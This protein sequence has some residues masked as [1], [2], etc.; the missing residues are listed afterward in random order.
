MYF[1]SVNALIAM[2]GHGPYVWSAYGITLVVLVGLVLAPLRRRRQ[3][4][5]NLRMRLRREQNPSLNSSLKN[6]GQHASGS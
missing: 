2:E 6:G 3:F 4:L 5:V 1:E